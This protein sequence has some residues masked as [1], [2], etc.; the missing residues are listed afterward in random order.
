V[1]QTVELVTWE[2]SLSS[3]E[4][5]RKIQRATSTSSASGNSVTTF[6]SQFPALTPLVLLRSV[7]LSSSR[8]IRVAAHC[9]SPCA[10]W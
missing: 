2:G 4:R 8:L 1:G 6:S 7:R 9:D 10:F 5:D 3:A